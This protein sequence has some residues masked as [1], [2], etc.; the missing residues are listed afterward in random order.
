MTK[1]SRLIEAILRQDLYCF[2]QAAF[3]IVSPG[4][5][6][7]PNWHL[8]AIAYHLT[9]VLEGE[10]KRLI[11]TIPP[12]SLKSICGSVCFPAFVLGHDPT[13]RII[14]VSYAESLARKHA[15]DCRAIMR[16][17]M[18]GR[19]FPNTRVS[20]A[21]DT[22]VE[23]ATTFGGNRLSTSVGGT[24]TG[25][26][27]NFIIIDDP[28]KPQ[29]AYSELARDSVKQWY[30]NTLLSRLDDK[31]NDAIVVIMQRLHI[32]D[33]VGH[34]LEQDGWTHLNL[35][36]I[37]EA[38]H[39]VPLGPGRFHLRRPGD[40]LHPEREPR[41]VLDEL[42]RSMGSRD[43]AAQYQQEPIA[44]GGNLIKWNW[45]QLY[46]DP[47]ARKSGDRI[48]ISWDTALSSKELSSYSACV[49]L[50][51]RDE[52]AYILDVVRDR[53]EYPDLKRKVIEVYRRWRNACSRCELV[54]ENKGSGMSLI[55]ELKRENIHAFPIDPQGDKVM[56]MNAETARIEA[57]SVFLPRVAHWLDDFR[58]EILP[59]PAGR[60]TDQIDALSQALHRAFTQRREEVNTGFIGMD[61]RISWS[62][63]RKRL[64]DKARGG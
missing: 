55:Q 60:Y 18:Y 51:V 28:L 20:L 29:D 37:A 12:R 24:L 22:E 38:E 45:F 10:I 14:C 15:N 25:R 5:P 54:I 13:R 8:E 3:P 23:F 57:G 64:F 42:K 6:F 47:P 40:V 4:A 7:A 48:I 46:D 21:K 32:D 30:A 19:L 63:D 59:F 43:F 31:N 62:D 41:T 33:L 56:R 16:S 35:P 11:I 39:S 36:A 17:A 26:G 1:D 58:S 52:T 50:Q 34:L 27:G 49:V 44:E 9:R 61:G 53:L 2:I